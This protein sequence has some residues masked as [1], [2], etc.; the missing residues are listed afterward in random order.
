MPTGEKARMLETPSF[1]GSEPGGVPPGIE[2]GQAREV[3]R[4][5]AWKIVAQTLWPAERWVDAAL[6]IVCE[7]AV[8]LPSRYVANCA[9]RRSR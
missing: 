1:S 3:R 9:P 7:D 5:D 4:V 6:D 2:R 8:R